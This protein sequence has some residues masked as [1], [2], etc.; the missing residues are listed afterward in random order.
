LVLLGVCVVGAVG[1][2]AAEAYGPYVVG[3]AVGFVGLADSTI[4][5]ASLTVSNCTFESCASWCQR[6]GATAPQLA[7]LA[8]TQR[9]SQCNAG[10]SSGGAVGNLLW[11]A[12]I[13]RVVA[14]VADSSFSNCFGTY[15]EKELLFGAQRGVELPAG[16]ERRLCIPV[17]LRVQAAAPP[18]IGMP[19]TKWTLTSSLATATSTVASRR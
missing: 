7:A 5:R 14:R 8:A 2:A 12:R 3:G 6:D 10:Y 1:E 16:A 4:S 9:E 18:S 13:D 11:N 17:R 15:G 19:A